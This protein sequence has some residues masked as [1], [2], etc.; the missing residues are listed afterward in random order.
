MSSSD[1]SGYETDCR[2]DRQETEAAE[3]DGEVRE[4]QK[5]RKT[6]GKK[7]KWVRGRTMTAHFFGFSSLFFLHADF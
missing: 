5:V 4:A 7:R 2:F 3:G 1:M 6:H